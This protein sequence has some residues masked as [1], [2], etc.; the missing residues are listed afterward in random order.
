MH[1]TNIRKKND[2]VSLVSQR[3]S[4][5]DCF[6]SPPPP[7]WSRPQPDQAIILLLSKHQPIFLA[8]SAEMISQV[9]YTPTSSTRRLMENTNRVNPSWLASEEIPSP[10]TSI[11]R[12]SAHLVS[13]SQARCRQSRSDKNFPSGNTRRINNGKQCAAA[14][15]HSHDECFPHVSAHRGKY[16]YLQ[17]VFI[18][19]NHIYT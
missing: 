2:E 19:F 13:A 18:V 9:T 7:T 3:W 17:F 10:Q 15:Y 11:D 4:V 5:I 16:T 12:F 14:Q 8:N 1:E 6:G